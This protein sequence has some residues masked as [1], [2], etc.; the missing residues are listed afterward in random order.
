MSPTA[1]MDLETRI[2]DIESSTQTVHAPGTVRMSDTLGTHV[3]LSPQ[4]TA[5]PNDPLVST[6]PLAV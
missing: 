5:D 2:V 4:P 3:V 6:D 1:K